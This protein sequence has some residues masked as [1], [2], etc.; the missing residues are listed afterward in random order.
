LAPTRIKG[1][2]PI[3]DRYEAHPEANRGPPA[4]QVGFSDCP[5]PQVLASEDAIFA[6][7]VS[8]ATCQ[9]K[10]VAVWALGKSLLTNV[11]R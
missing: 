7:E 5:A 10:G 11:L 3:N 6:A 9:P 2:E 8:T 1:S 4:A